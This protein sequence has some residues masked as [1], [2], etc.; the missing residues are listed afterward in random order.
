LPVPLARIECE[1]R[2]NA[3]KNVALE[4]NIEARN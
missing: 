1:S 2:A 4:A 3:F